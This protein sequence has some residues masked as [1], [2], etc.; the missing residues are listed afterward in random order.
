M[1]LSF[2]HNSIK[3]YSYDAQQFTIHEMECVSHACV[4]VLSSSAVTFGSHKLC[5]DVPM[6]NKYV[7]IF[8]RRRYC[9]LLR[10]QCNNS[11]V[12]DLFLSAG[13]PLQRL[14]R[15]CSFAISWRNSNYSWL[16]I[17][18][19]IQ[20]N[21]D[22]D[23]V[24]LL[25]WKKNEK[26]EIIHLMNSKHGNQFWGTHFRV[27]KC[28]YAKMCPATEDGCSFFVCIL[29]RQ[30]NI[31]NRPSHSYLSDVIPSRARL[32]QLNRHIKISRTH[33]GL[34]CVA[35]SAKCEREIPFHIFILRSRE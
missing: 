24:F 28:S 19:K 8:L 3:N 26:N 31:V 14:L 4:R 16:Y 7:V 15:D 17:R 23:G 13:F 12:N 9:S 35:K 27:R 10:G 2:E 5:C 6:M 34:Y 21:D 29:M 18:K 33:F 32:T 1:S 25:L 20:A 22:D 11:S 30:R